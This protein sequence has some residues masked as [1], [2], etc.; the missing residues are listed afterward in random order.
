MV[1][2]YGIILVLYVILMA[3]CV[4][5][6]DIHHIYASGHVLW[7][8]TYDEHDDIHLVVFHYN[9]CIIMVVISKF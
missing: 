2:S 5:V 8:G 1:I 4:C 6:Y 9:T 7:T 3:F